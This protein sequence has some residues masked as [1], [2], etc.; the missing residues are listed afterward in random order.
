MSV[1]RESGFTLIELMIVVVII[2]ILAAIGVP[3]FAHSRERAFLA[4]M[5]SDL[6]N[7]ETAQEAYYHDQG[8]YYNGII[9]NTTAFSFQP[10]TAVTL[11]MATVTAGGWQAVAQHS[12]TTKTCAVFLGNVS[13]L[14][15]AV[16]EGVPGCN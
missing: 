2:G 8:A 15:P 1:G 10:S 12:Q 14:S 9:P 16:S 4:T 5:K 13:P 6:H 3:K 11:T 7:L